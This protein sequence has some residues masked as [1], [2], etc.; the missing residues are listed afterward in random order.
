LKKKKRFVFPHFLLQLDF[1]YLH[2]PF[3]SKKVTMPTVDWSLVHFD[4]VEEFVEW[5]QKKIGEKEWNR[6]EGKDEFEWERKFKQMNI[7]VRTRYGIRL[8]LRSYGAVD[9]N[10]FVQLLLTNR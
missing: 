1:F 2:F 4:T 6:L 5:F 3:V 10:S 7:P 9:G 8:I